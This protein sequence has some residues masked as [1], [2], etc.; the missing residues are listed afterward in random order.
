[1]TKL[2]WDAAADRRFE[3]GVDHGVLY[4]PNN[5]GEYDDG[6]AWNGL[7]SVSEAPEGA[8]SNYQYADNIQYLN[9]MSAELFK[10]TI[11]AFTYPTEFEPFDGVASPQIGVA[12]GQQPRKSFGLSYRTK[13]GNALNA[14]LGYKIHVV[15]GAF[16]AP[17]EKAYQTVNDSPE[18]ITFSW[19]LTTTPIPVGTIGGTDYKPTS[20][21]VVD[22]TKVDAGALADLEEL[23]YGTVGQDPQ[24][25]TP[26]QIIALFAGTVVDAIP[27]AP[28]Y[29]SSTDTLTIPS[30]T[31]IQYRNDA[32]QEVYTSGG[33]VI[34][35]DVLVKA[36]ALP[37]YRIPPGNDVTWFIDQT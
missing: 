16:A 10:A 32:T 11:E 28:T 2:T 26:A 31:G 7:V 23:L 8:E 34:A 17:S 3:N 19:E 13:V 4:I 22:S 5:L 36:Y 37:G 27:T 24:L 14:E 1:M 15:Y 25:P 18:A 29:N 9:L 33:H 30:V 12:I 21:L 35:A 20:T 6:V